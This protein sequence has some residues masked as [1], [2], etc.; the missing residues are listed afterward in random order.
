[1]SDPN[2]PQYKPGDIVNGHQ[3]TEQKDGTLSWVA[4]PVAAPQTETGIPVKRKWYT[5]KR[6]II[7]AAVLL[8]IIIISSINRPPAKVDDAADK[9]LEIVQTTPKKETPKEPEVV[10]VTVPDVTGMD[11]ATAIAALR[12]AGFQVADPADA[13]FIVT[14]TAPAKGGIADEGATVT[15]TLEAPKPQLTIGQENAV[16]KGRSY[17]AM[18][19]FSRSGLIEQLQFEGF[20]PEDA[21]F[22]ADFIAPDWAAECAEKAKSYMDMMAFSRDGLY[23]QL[24]FE[25]FADAEINA[26]LAAVGY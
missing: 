7:P 6:I 19:G 11:A 25:G 2:T 14:A 22:A 16:S 23:E 15:L 3:L 17:L 12:A 20:S 24:A 9:G 18:M 10:K 5:R 21:T 13:T 26:G 8:L 4:V 1:M